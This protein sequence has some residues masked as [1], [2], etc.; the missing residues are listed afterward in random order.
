MNKKIELND[1]DSSI[2]T[3]KK[4]DFESMLKDRIDIGKNL[5]IEPVKIISIGHSSFGTPANK[6]DHKEKNVFL[7]KYQKWNQFNLELLKRSFNKPSNEYFIEYEK[8]T[9]TSVWSDWVIE[10]KET[11]Q[12]QITT[13]ESIIE[14]LP[15]IPEY[16]KEVIAIEHRVAS[17]KI[18]IVHGHNNEIKQTVARTVEQLKLKPII[19]HEQSEQGRTIIEKFEKNSSDVNFAIILLTNDDEGKSKKETTFKNRARQNVVFEMGYFIG[20]LGRQR[21]FLLLENGVD[22]PGDLDGIVYVPIDN[23]EGWKLKLVRELKEAG[24]N[25]SADNL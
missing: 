21:V 15:L 24:Y 9:R 4:E 14:R 6:Y 11:I 5:I 19:L 2:L 17:D 22:K 7:S 1:L 8:T 18:F 10:Y 3:I 20:K 16:N 13:I 23:S 25:V 12:N